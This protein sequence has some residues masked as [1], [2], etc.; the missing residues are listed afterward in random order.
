MSPA[1]N[2]CFFPV[3]RDP[4]E[5]VRGGKKKRKEQITE[6]LGFDVKIL[7]NAEQF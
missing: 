5:T 1:T 6:N 2:S 7:R 4:H 3:K